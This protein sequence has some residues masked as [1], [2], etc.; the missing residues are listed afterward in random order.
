M[1]ALYFPFF[2]FI[3]FRKNNPSNFQ[4]SLESQ[5]E[6]FVTYKLTYHTLT[7][8]NNVSITT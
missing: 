8:M 3:F 6:Y 1:Q 5:R 4:Y 2:F 7:F